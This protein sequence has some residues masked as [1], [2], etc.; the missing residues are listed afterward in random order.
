MAFYFLGKFVLIC[1]R[2]YDLEILFDFFQVRDNLIGSTLVDLCEIQ[3]RGSL[4]W[5]LCNDHWRLTNASVLLSSS[6]STGSRSTSLSTGIHIWIQAA[7][8]NFFSSG[9]FLPYF[10]LLILS[11]PLLALDSVYVGQGTST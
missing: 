7:Q 4:K 2:A 11:L 8:H 6:V 10:N 1:W 5:K 9:I 3:F